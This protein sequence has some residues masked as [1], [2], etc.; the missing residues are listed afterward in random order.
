MAGL[1]KTKKES[2]PPNLITDPRLFPIAVGS[3]SNPPWIAVEANN[4]D[5][6]SSSFWTEFTEMGTYIT[7]T[8]AAAYVTILNF[9]NLTKP[10]VVGNV[11]TAVPNATASHKIRFTVDGVVTTIEPTTQWSGRLVWGC[12]NMEARGVSATV[13]NNI[14]WGWRRLHTYGYSFGS[15]NGYSTPNG[16]IEDVMDMHAHGWPLLLAEKSLKI[17]AYDSVVSSFS[18]YHQWRGATWRYLETF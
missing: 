7:T 9:T 1:T 17:E 18:S 5:A 14:G 6:D 15:N 11:L 10:V 8:T 3:G 16:V 4:Y 13:A 12:Q 2:R